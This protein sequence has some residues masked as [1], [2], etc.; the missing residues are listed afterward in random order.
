MMVLASHMKNAGDG[1][2]GLSWTT[3]RRPVMSKTPAT[4]RDFEKNRSGI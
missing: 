4:F 1:R 3:R 2:G